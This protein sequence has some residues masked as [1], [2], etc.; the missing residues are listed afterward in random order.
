MKK[1]LIFTTIFTLF[2][3]SFSQKL[4]GMFDIKLD[5]NLKTYSSV[6]QESLESVIY[7]YNSKKTIGIKLDERTGFKDSL[8]ITYK[9][10]YTKIIAD[11]TN[12][13]TSKI[14]YTDDNFTSFVIQE[15]DFKN[16]VV[17]N[18]EISFDIFSRKFLQVFFVNDTLYILA[19]S[20]NNNTV[21]VTS[22]K[23]DKIVENKIKFSGDKLISILKFKDCTFLRDQ[24]DFQ[25]KLMNSKS[26]F[27]SSNTKAL[28]KCYVWE[29]NFIATLDNTNETTE[30]L[31][32][33]LINN[34]AKFNSLKKELIG[35]PVASN[36]LIFEDKI[37]QASVSKENNSLTVWDLNGNQIKN[38]QNNNLQ[39]PFYFI[40]NPL[41]NLI[42]TEAKKYY[43]NID[44]SSF[45]I[46]AFENYDNVILNI[47]CETRAK[48]P[49][50]SPY[51]NTNYTTVGVI[52]GGL[53][54]GL[55]GA[56]IDS[57]SSTNSST[58]PDFLFK[59]NCFNQLQLNSSNEVV[60]SP[61][62]V[63]STFKLKNDILITDQTMLP[64]IFNLNQNF[65]LGYYD[66]KESRYF[67]KMFKNN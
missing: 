29:N 46:V 27:L 30:I 19:I 62:S 40:E 37:Y 56:I 12:E 15:F 57:N 53:V 23:D 13:N 59:A 9:N 3:F 43:R 60:N 20:D 55:I 54:G 36:S 24:L 21:Y 2:N 39:N 61:K 6:N 22:Y 7:F 58:Y 33:D 28:S 16:K 25:L 18:K 44:K 49:E 34:T 1:Y 67:I 63:F 5:K 64:L 65:Y 42:H 4:T 50:N 26:K 10:N 52:A 41:G 14:V 45:S 35:N 38:I 11:Y 17:R 31:Q 48:F 47:G 51:K 8:S 32:I 66:K